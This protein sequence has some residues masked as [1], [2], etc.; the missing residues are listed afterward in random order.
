MVRLKAHEITSA[1]AGIRPER[2][3]QTTQFRCQNET[4]HAWQ[5]INTYQWSKKP[6]G[7]FLALV[8]R[9]APPVM[10]CITGPHPNQT[11]KRGHLVGEQRQWL[12]TTLCNWESRDKS[13]QHRGKPFPSLKLPYCLW[14]A[15]KPQLNLIF[16]QAG[17]KPSWLKPRELAGSRWGSAPLPVSWGQRRDAMLASGSPH[18]WPKLPPRCFHFRFVSQSRLI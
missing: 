12:S 7:S 18:G 8:Y 14:Y 6:L 4:C 9:K 2:Q 1:L 10:A 13:G 16:K 17:L 15:G 5:C 11:R 3:V